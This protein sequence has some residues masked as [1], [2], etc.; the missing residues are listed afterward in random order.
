MFTGRGSAAVFTTTANNRAFTCLTETTCSPAASRKDASDV[1]W[2]DDANEGAATSTTIA[3]AAVN[4]R[5]PADRSTS[6]H[7]AGNSSNAY[8]FSTPCKGTIVTATTSAEAKLAG[9]TNSSSSQRF[10]G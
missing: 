5:L 10:A 4:R 3:P 7:L 6:D 2:P 8:T 9:T 1:G